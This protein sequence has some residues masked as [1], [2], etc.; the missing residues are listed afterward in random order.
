MHQPRAVFNRDQ[1][2][3]PGQ[4]QQMNQSELEANTC[5]RRRAQENVYKQVMICFWFY[6]LIG[7]ES[8]R[9][10]NQNKRELLS[11]MNWKP[12]Y[13]EFETEEN[14]SCVYI[15]CWQ[16]WMNRA[17]VI[18]DSQTVIKTKQKQRS[19]RTRFY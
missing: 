18:K 7:R 3:Y 12:L 16:A 14:I 13:F 8:G 6:R 9:K 10:Q 5:E 11:A 17:F 2:N 15:A 19:K 4:S 1:S